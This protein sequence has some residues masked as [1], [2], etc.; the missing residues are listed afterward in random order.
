MSEG[1]LPIDEADVVVIGTGAFGLTAT[2]QLSALGAGRVVALDRFVVGSQTSP[3]AAGLFKMV[4]PDATLTALALLSVQIVS[5][6]EATTGVACPH[7]RSGSI[8][9]ARTPEHAAMIRYETEQS[10]RWG[11]ELTEICPAEVVGLAP[12]LEADAMLAAF[13]SPGD[14]YVEEP[15]TML[16]AYR[17]AAEARGSRIFGETPVTAIRVE[18]GRVA[19]VVTPRGEIGAPLVIDAAGCWAAAIGALAGVAV[20]VVPMRHQL[21]ITEPIAGVS[22]EHPITRIVD[23]SVYLRPARGGL[24]VG[25]FETD[26]LPLD[27]RRGDPEF[28]MA[29]VPLDRTVLDRMEAPVLDQVP[30]L[31]EVGTNEHR[32]GL[33]TMT[34]DARFLVGPAPGIEGFWLVTGCNGS[35]FSLS[36]GIAQV[37]AEWIV[38]GKPSI[39]LS[40]LD[41]RRVVQRPLDEAAL[42]AAAVEQYANYYTP[43]A[44]HVG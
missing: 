3:R 7:V 28:T 27:P 16:E 13:H 23:A 37:L 10:R 30:A 17:L 25:G 42:V 2:Y 11:V 5:S 4:Q 6:F 39:D 40:S 18:D 36:S 34:A 1:R 20:P 33:F 41:P 26:P 12:Y 31:R 8:L 9:M 19:G 35:G 15:A 44:A 24:M 38:E 32:G 29:D 14:L 43:E 22:P 21:R